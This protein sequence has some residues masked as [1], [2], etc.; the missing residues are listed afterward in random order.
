MVEKA[1]G[2]E[3]LSEGISLLEGKSNTVMKTSNTYPSGFKSISI[4]LVTSR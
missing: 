3:R 2:E 1:S 4:G